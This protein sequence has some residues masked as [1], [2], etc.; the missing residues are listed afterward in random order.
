[1]ACAAL[2]QL[3]YNQHPMLAKLVD[4]IKEQYMT[5]K[6]VSWLFPSLRLAVLAPT[7]CGLPRCPLRTFDHGLVRNG[8]DGDC[9]LRQAVEELATV[10][11]P[12][13]IETKREFVK[14]V[15]EVLVCHG[16]LVRTHQPAFEQR[17]HQMY[18]RHEYRWRF[19]FAMQKSDLMIVPGGRS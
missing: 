11:R 1:M 5:E 7:G 19:A 8:I 15:I 3:R 2:L 4:W 17:H 10:A 6:S 14:V 12:A 13:P 9:L 16:S 18:P